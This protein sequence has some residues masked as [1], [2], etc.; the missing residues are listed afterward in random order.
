MWRWS[1]AKRQRQNELRGCLGGLGYE[2]STLG[3]CVCV[4]GAAA[5]TDQAYRTAGDEST[6]SHPGQNVL[7]GDTLNTL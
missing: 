1:M 3:C 6:K 5:Q 4:W 7:L 2:E